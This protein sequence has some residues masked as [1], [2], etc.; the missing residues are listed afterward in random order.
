MDIHIRHA[1]PDEADALTEL[2]HAAK[3]YWGYP[4]NW[5][6]RWRQALTITPDFIANNEMFA[7]ISGDEIVGRCA[8]VISDSV[9]ELEHMWIK[10]EHMGAGVARALFLHAKGPR[11]KT[12]G[13]HA[14]TLSRSECRRLLSANARDAYRRSS[15]R[16]RRAAARA[17]TDADGDLNC[18]LC[19]DLR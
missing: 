6:E 11:G 7:A 19:F 10:P 9:A 17:A 5:I 14:R 12:E 13:A 4:E 16:D 1:K 3:R 15:I 18:A 8:L 2:A